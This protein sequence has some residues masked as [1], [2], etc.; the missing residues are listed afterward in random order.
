MFSKLKERVEQYV[1]SKGLKKAGAA[2]AVWALGLLGS[3]KVAQVL[4]QAGVTVDPAELKTYIEGLVILGGTMAYNFVK[5][6]LEHKDE[7]AP[8]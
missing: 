3:A 8:K 5:F 2:V 1:L 6:K 4:G 7:V